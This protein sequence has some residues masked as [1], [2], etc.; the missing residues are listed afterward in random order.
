MNIALDK[1]N[2]TQ[3]FRVTSSGGV[4]SG[5][6]AGAAGDINHD[7][8]GDMLLGQ[9]V[10]YGKN[11]GYSNPISLGELNGTYGFC[12]KQDLGYSTASNSA[13]D[14][15]GDG[16]SDIIVG[17]SD[18]SPFGYSQA[19]AAYVVYG[20]KGG[21]DSV[22]LDTLLSNKHGFK[23]FGESVGAMAGNSV[24]SAGDIN[25]DGIDDM[26]IGS[27]GFS[28]L[29][30]ISVGA[31][32]VL[33]GKERGYSYN[34]ELSALNG[35]N[36][37]K[38]TGEGVGDKSGFSVSGLGDINGDGVA[39]IGIGAPFASPLGRKYAG[40]SYVLYGKKGIRPY[41]LDL[42]KLESS[43]G[44]KIFGST[45]Q[46]HSGYGVSGLGDINADGLDDIGISAL[47]VSSESVQ[48]AT[49]YVV[50]GKKGGYI[51][52]IDLA[53]LNTEVSFK[54]SSL[55]PCMIVAGAG[56]INADHIPDITFSQ[57][58]CYISNSQVQQLYVVYGRKGGYENIDLSR[59][60]HGWKVTTGTVGT[61]STPIGGVGDVNN[62]S[63]DDIYFTTSYG[64]YL[65]YVVY[66]QNSS[67]EAPSELMHDNDL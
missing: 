15:N 10:V 60:E 4:N 41:E 55:P 54:I 27:P 12:M 7:G 25:G 61:F 65:G 21:Y 58:Y 20:R 44:F 29:E 66:G 50:Y 30:N 23:V 46:E 18:S 59:L 19:G 43:N 31:S 16:I 1:L 37:L 34:I 28:L 11:G 57:F 45:A 47:P 13:G 64:E 17:S 14:V 42:K 48:P 36:G 53:E 67:E 35:T 49:I 62:D 24:S 3:C 2:A 40:V 51:E 33:Y 63:I 56:D 9:N 5:V 6:V 52:S 38:V 26:I 32:Y 39:D 8:I 22:N